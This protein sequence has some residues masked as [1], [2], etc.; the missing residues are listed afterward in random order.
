MSQETSGVMAGL[1]AFSQVMG[2]IK[3]ASIEIM[4]IHPLN[5]LIMLNLLSNIGYALTV[6]EGEFIFS[7]GP[8]DPTK[9]DERFETRQE[10]L[11]HIFRVSG[12]KTGQLLGAETV[13]NL[14]NSFSLDRVLGKLIT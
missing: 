12:I 6:P 11:A 1:T 10:L 8:I 3:N 14:F 5:S 7:S 4:Q 9:Q 2:E 13:G